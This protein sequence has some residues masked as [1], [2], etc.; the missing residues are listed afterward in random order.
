MQ[1]ND[2]NYFQVQ[3]WMVT[4]LGLKTVERDVFAIIYGYS[5]DKESD[6]HG[7]LSYMSELTGYSK[8]SICTALKSLT[9]K[10]FIIKSEQ[11]INNIK[12][13]RYTISFDTIQASCTGIQATCI[14]NINN[15]K[16]SI[17]V[18]SKD[19]TSETEPDLF[20]FGE[21]ESKKP[22]LYQKCIALINSWTDIP[23]LRNLLKQYL[24]VCMEMKCIRGANQWK[25]MLNTLEK[26]QQQCHPCKYE[27]IIKQSIDHGWKT[28]YPINNYQPKNKC[29]DNVQSE[30]KKDYTPA[31]DENGNPIV[32]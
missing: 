30:H 29:V 20:Q 23:E 24:D 19:N 31:L 4:K 32:F 9:E 12:C 28:F 14:N 8:N 15:N 1:V 21:T 16:N 25:G 5:Q 2:N 11:V 17:N 26:V 13:C 6:F 22:N 10:N 18:L 27:D 7:S 3:A